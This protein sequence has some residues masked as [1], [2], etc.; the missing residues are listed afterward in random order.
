MGNSTP[1]LMAGRHWRRNA[2]AAVLGVAVAGLLVFGAFGFRFSSTSPSS[3]KT[4]ADG[5]TFDHALDQLN[6]SVQ[7]TS[8][9]PWTL[10]TVYGVAAPVPFSPSALGWIEQNRTVNSC[11]QLLNGLTLWNGSIPL[12]NGTFNSGTAPFW[13]FFYFSNASQSILIATDVLGKT[14]VFPPMAMSSPC[15]EGSSLSYEPWGYANAYFKQL[16]SD[17]SVLAETATATV[18]AEWLNQDGPVFETYRFGNN[19][20]GSGNPSGYIIN[21][22]RCGDVGSAGVQPFA[23]IGLT[24]TGSFFGSFIGDEGCGNVAEIGPPPVL[25]P[26]QLGFSSPSA[27]VSNRSTYVTLP[28]QALLTNQSGTVG[29][30]AGGIVS[31]MVH[32]RLTNASGTALPAGPVTCGTWVPTDRDCPANSSGWFAVLQSPYGEWLDSYGSSTQGSNWSVP[33]VS[34]VSNQQFVVVCPASWNITGD[35]LTAS[36]TTPNAPLSGSGTLS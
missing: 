2:A 9:G 30:D 10:Y 16:P 25:Y 4:I 32:L 13:Q 36:S 24:A 18:G 28:F 3:A 35:V 19:Y 22:E 15:M 14:Q 33:N 8:G 26:Y 11:G 21:F 31:W 12:F 20:W 23:S 27:V 34:L 5:P 7:G 17:S 29:T 6:A 1:S